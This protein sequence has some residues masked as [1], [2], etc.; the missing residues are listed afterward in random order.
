MQTF[1]IKFQYFISRQFNLQRPLGQTAA[2]GGKP[3]IGVHQ[4]DR[5]MVKHLKLK[6]RLIVQLTKETFVC[7]AV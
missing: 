1:S 3:D 4:D 6:A 2:G 7:L 5:K